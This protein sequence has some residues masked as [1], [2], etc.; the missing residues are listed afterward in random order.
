MEEK[1]NRQSSPQDEKGKRRSAEEYY[2]A[3]VNDH[4]PEAM[5]SLGMMYENGDEVEQDYAEGVKWFRKAADQKH[6]EAMKQLGYAYLMGQGVEQD[7]R[8]AEY[9]YRQAAVSWYEEAAA[10]HDKAA[11]ERLRQLNSSR[12]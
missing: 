4:D 10:L 2:Q 12:S 7:Y 3:A 11:A 5:C 6:T 9:W 1:R 8:A